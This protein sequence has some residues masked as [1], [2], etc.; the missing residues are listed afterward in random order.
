[1]LNRNTKQRP[2]TN[3]LLKDKFLVQLM[4]NTINQK[5]SLKNE[6]SKGQEAPSLSNS[7]LDRQTD[8]VKEQLKKLS[9]E[10]G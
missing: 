9:I 2:L 7:L 10:V 3:E 6:Y 1:M 8:S 4:V 5:G